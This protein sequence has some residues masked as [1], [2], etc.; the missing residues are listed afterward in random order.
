[1]RMRTPM[2]RGAR[3]RSPISVARA[4]T[5]TDDR[6]CAVT[7]FHKDGGRPDE[8]NPIWTAA[9]IS[10]VT[11]ALLFARLARRHKPADDAPVLSVAAPAFALR[12][13]PMVAARIRILGFCCVSWK[14][15]QALFCARRADRFRGKR[16]EGRTATLVFANCCTQTESIKCLMVCGARHAP[17]T[18]L[19]AVDH[20]DRF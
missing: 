10:A 3:K 15:P 17:G 1:M 9:L 20:R 12:S 11:K 5:A 14:S 4:I 6:G 7:V 2:K 13:P 16:R 18:D 8:A 19:L